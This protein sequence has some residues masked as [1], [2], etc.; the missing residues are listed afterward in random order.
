MQMG[1]LQNLSFLLPLYRQPGPFATA[2]IDVSRRTE[3]AAHRIALEWRQKRETLINQG[4]S[5]R[6]VAAMDNAVVEQQAGRGSPAPCTQ[7]VVAAAGRVLLNDEC[8]RA[9]PDGRATWGALPDLLPMLSA[10]PPQVSYLVA[11]VDRVGA[12]LIVYGRRDVE[13]DEV[14]GGTYPIRKVAPGGWSQRRYQQRAEN[15]W[16]ANAHRVAE[17]VDRLARRHHTRVIVLSGDVRAKTALVDALSEESRAEVVEIEGGG[18]AAGVDEE[19]MLEATNRAVIDRGSAEA[20]S[21]RER[22]VA[23]LGRGGRAVTGMSDTIGA[24]RRGQVAVLLLPDSGVDQSV[25][26][27]SEPLELGTEQSDVLTDGAQSFR[28]DAALLRAAAANGAA[29][30]TVEPD[31]EALPGPAGALLRY[32]M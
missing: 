2:Y 17:Q 29:L 18:R 21:L 30:L 7:V 20:R 19:A 10:S 22:F 9:W 25:W 16:S 12:D 1:G 28:G 3:D 24:L 5:E 11:R 14:R 31:D 15:L 13:V 27:G 23:E 8:P 32:E 6:V 4:A 26:I